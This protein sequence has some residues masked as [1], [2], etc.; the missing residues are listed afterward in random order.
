ML[1]TMVNQAKQTLLSKLLMKVPSQGGAEQCV[2]EGKGGG[3]AH[4]SCTPTGMGR[5]RERMKKTSKLAYR[6]LQLEH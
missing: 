4:T 6:P 1:S 2:E 5:E 3:A